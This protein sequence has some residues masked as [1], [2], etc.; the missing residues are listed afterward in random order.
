MNFNY[1]TK[2]FLFQYHEE[3]DATRHCALSRVRRWTFLLADH[4]CERLGVKL[5]PGT[6]LPINADLPKSLSSL[7][8]GSTCGSDSESIVS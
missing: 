5:V 8:S 1:K 3:I 4:F 2:Q 6:H 7:D